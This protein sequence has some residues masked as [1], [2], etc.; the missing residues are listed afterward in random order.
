MP[1]PPSAALP[2][3]RFGVLTRGALVVCPRRQI[4]DEIGLGGVVSAD[5]ARKK[6]NNLMAK[7]RV[8]KMEIVSKGAVGA[9]RS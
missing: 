4:L 6:W 5:Q 3:G 1:W 2:A 7:Y 9:Q 8:E